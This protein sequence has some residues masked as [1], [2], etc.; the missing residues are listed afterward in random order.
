MGPGLLAHVSESKRRRRVRDISHRAGPSCLMQ[1]RQVANGGRDQEIST[2]RPV[3]RG[4]DHPP[5]GQKMPVQRWQCCSQALI[6]LLR[7]CLTC[8]QAQ[9]YKAR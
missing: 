7:A 8:R 9:L 6:R 4:S 3:V 5:V 1:C 2:G